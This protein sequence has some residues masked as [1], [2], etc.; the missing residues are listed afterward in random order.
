MGRCRDT[1][2]RAVWVSGIIA[3]GIPRLQR[4]E[5]YVSHGRRE[6][7]AIAGASG[8]TTQEQRRSC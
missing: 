8:G 3:T 7:F 1:K 4:V 2:A 6:P 5:P